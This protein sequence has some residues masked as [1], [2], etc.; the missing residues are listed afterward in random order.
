MYLNGKVY[1]LF[2]GWRYS[3]MLIIPKITQFNLKGIYKITLKYIRKRICAGITN[4]VLEK[5]NEKNLPYT[6]SK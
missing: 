4:A 3:K 1:S 6:I 2:S 5:S